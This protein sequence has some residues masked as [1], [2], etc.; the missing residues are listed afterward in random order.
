MKILLTLA[1]FLS[2]S[3]LTHAQLNGVVVLKRHHK[4]IE[5][6]FEGKSIE[7][8]N[9]DGQRISG[10]ITGVVKDTL[11]LRFIDVQQRTNYWGLPSMDTLREVPLAY[12][13]SDIKTVVR[14]R[15]HL[16][17]TAD[18]I[19]LIAAGAGLLII[20]AV[21]TAYY[22]EPVSDVASG[23]VLAS[24]V[25][26]MALGTWLITLQTQHYHLGKKYHLEYLGF[27]T[28]HQ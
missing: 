3:L 19:I 14:T 24:S 28:P 18:G 15:T 13:F 10:I 9:Q 27:T 1:V 12:A 26:L 2:L 11:L 20:S 5:R 7:F 17:Y 6:Y 8:I 16:N 4:T 25:G 23:A 22:K 21:N